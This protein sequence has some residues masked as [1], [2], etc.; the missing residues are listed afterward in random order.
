MVD[1]APLRDLAQLNLA[2]YRDL[3]DYEIVPF[4]WVKQSPTGTLARRSG[5][6]GF[7]HWFAE[8]H[9]PSSKRGLWLCSGATPQLSKGNAQ[10][11]K[12]AN[13][14]VRWEPSQLNVIKQ[15]RHPSSRRARSTTLRIIAGSK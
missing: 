7:A 15:S 2:H 8:S 5:R 13:D 12:A 11:E 10:L 9:I 1:S 3:E 4:S 14:G 6:E